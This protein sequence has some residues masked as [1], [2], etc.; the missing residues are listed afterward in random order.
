MVT[1]VSVSTAAQHIEVPINANNNYPNNQAGFVVKIN[2]LRRGTYVLRQLNN[3]ARRD[4]CKIEACSN[5]RIVCE[6]LKDCP[7][8][9]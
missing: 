1:C 5:D 9:H 4:D 2:F 6:L 8:F 7:P 3:S